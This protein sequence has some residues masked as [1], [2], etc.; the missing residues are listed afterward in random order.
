[1]LNDSTQINSG[2]SVTWNPGENTLSITVKNGDAQ[3]VY[4]VIVTKS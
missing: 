1:M 2:E 4:T 3:Q